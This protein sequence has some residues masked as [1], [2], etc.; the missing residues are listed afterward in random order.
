MCCAR[1][2]EGDNRADGERDSRLVT[3]QDPDDLPGD[4]QAG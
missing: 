4:G 2:E 1:Q 3:H